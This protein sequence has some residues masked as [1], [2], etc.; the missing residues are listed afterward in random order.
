MKIKQN[1]LFSYGNYNAYHSF[2][3]SYSRNHKQ[4]IKQLVKEFKERNSLDAQKEW[5][6]TLEQQKN[7]KYWDLIE[8]KNKT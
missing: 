2:Y 6:K 3:H 7:W 5:Q 4:Q 1:L 8:K